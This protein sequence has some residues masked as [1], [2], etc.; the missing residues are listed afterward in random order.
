MLR[1]KLDLPDRD[2][3]RGLI[4]TVLLGTV[5]LDKR[6]E[7]QVDLRPEIDATTPDCFTKILE[8]RR[9]RICA[10]IDEHHEPATTFYER[11]QAG[12]VEVPAISEIAIIRQVIGLRKKLPHEIERPQSRLR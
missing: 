12:V 3:R 4:T 11:I 7:I 2:T 10:A 9:L 5:F 8:T 1:R 6:I